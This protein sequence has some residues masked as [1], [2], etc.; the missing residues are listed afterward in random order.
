MTWTDAKNERRNPAIGG[1]YPRKGQSPPF[2]GTR[3]AT[4]VGTQRFDSAAGHF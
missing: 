4:A 1:D 3:T 2:E